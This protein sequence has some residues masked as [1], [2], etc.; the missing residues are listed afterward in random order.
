MDPSWGWGGFSCLRSSGKPYFQVPKTDSL[1]RGRMLQSR[2]KGLPGALCPLQ[3]WVSKEIPGGG[4][5]S[6]YSAGNE[7][8]GKQKRIQECSIQRHKSLATASHFQGGISPGTAAA[9]HGDSGTEESSCLPWE[10]LPRPCFH[11]LMLRSLRSSRGLGP[12]GVPARAADARPRGPGPP[13]SCSLGQL[14]VVRAKQPPRAPPAPVQQS[15]GG[16]TKDPQR[17][18]GGLCT[19]S[20]GSPA[21]AGG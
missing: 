2:Q 13:A 16:C 18:C 5:P 12:H 10:A 6:V 11:H 17:G 3:S 4:G 8:E 7:R 15:P 20:L 9:G 1:R 14:H 21:S 19:K